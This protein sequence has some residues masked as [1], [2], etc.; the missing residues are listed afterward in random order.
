[1]RAPSLP[2]YR[3]RVERFLAGFRE[4]A[5]CNRDRL[6]SPSCANFQNATG[7]FNK[8]DAIGKS[9][10]CHEEAWPRE[11]GFLAGGDVLARRPIPWAEGRHFGTQF[12]H[13]L[14]FVPASTN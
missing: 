14:N 8:G 9:F 1:M 10:T 4:A 7:F 13:I 6:H 2:D 5:Y 11:H 3:A 12:I